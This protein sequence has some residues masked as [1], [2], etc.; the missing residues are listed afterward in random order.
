MALAGAIVKV[1]ARTRIHRARQHMRPREPAWQY[2]GNVEQ[3]L[4]GIDLDAAHHSRFPGIKF[5]NNEPRNFLAAGFN[6]NR[7]RTADPAYSAIQRKLTDEDAVLKF[8]L[9]QSAVGSEDA[10]RH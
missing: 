4:H 9:V 3:R 10:Q 8:F 5:R 7:K 1:S 6:G 2:V